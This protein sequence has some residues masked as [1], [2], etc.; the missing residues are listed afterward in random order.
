MADLRPQA[1]IFVTEYI[2][3]GN[4][5]TQAAIAAG[6]SERTASSQGSRLLKSVEVQQFLNKTEQNLNK[7]LRVM[8]ADHA[9]NAFNVLLEVMNDPEAQHKDKLVAARDLLDRAGYKPT[10]KV[11]AD[12]NTEGT[13]QIVFSDKMKK[14]DS[15]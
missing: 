5:A 6:Y 2:R 13:I 11:V 8:F 1:M 14:A 15:S 9:V 12:V 10:D 7:D 3:N 4:N